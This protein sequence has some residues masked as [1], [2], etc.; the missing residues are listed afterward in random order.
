[1]SVFWFQVLPHEVDELDAVPVAMIA[2]LPCPFRLRGS[3]PIGRA[4]A[5]RE[6]DSERDLTDR[7]RRVDFSRVVLTAT[8]DLECERPGQEE[9]EQEEEEEEEEEES[10]D[11]REQQEEGKELSESSSEQSEKSSECSQEAAPSTLLADDQREGQC[12]LSAFDGEQEQ[13]EA[14]KTLV[15][16]SPGDLHKS[17]T[18]GELA[19]DPDLGT[20][21]AVTPQS[22]R[23]Q[24]LGSQLDVSE[25]GTLSSIIKSET[26]PLCPVV[27][28]VTSCP[29]TKV[30]RTFLHIAEKTHLNIMSSSGQLLPHDHYE[31]FQPRE[32]QNG[33]YSMEHGQPT[34]PSPTAP[35]GGETRVQNGVGTG[36]DSLERTHEPEPVGRVEPRHSPE[37]ETRQEGEGERRKTL[38]GDGHLSTATSSQRKSRIPVLMSEEDTGSDH[39]ASVS[40][41]TRLS[42]RRSRHL[43]LARVL[44]NK[45]Q[46]RLIHLS[47]LTSSSASS[48]EERRA[49]SGGS[50]ITASEEDTNSD[51]SLNRAAK[52][53]EAYPQPTRPHQAGSS[54]SKI[55][56]PITLG[57]ASAVVSSPHSSIIKQPA[58]HR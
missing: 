36:E 50:P 7:P 58:T 29:F 32:T 12:R 4:V 56:R 13:E 27:T 3:L 10:A 18:A 20:L 25:P 53:S 14:S 45:R 39:S 6:V 22:E 37:A 28:A 46:C 2:D 23:P 21:A 33:G 34:A 16:F 41:K 47:S 55:P 35:Q 26:K 49:A 5:A 57:K 52:G 43:D 17:P 8:F 48:G 54:K 42:Q 31:F 38:I 24:A 9:E 15:L 11:V 30:E 51:S 40:F 1:M 44:M 19:P